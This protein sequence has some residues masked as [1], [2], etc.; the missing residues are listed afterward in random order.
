MI[1]SAEM[2]PLESVPDETPKSSSRFVWWLVVMGLGLLFLPLYMTAAALQ[3][4]SDS[5]Q[6]DLAIYQATLTAV[7]TVD[8]QT[9]A[10][11]DA[12]SETRV[13]IAQLDSANLSTQHVNWPLIASIIVNYDVT[14]LAVF[15]VQQ[16]GY[17]VVV[18]GQATSE[19]AVMNYVQALSDSEQFKRVVLQSIKLTV[20]TSPLPSGERAARLAEF[21][22]LL[23][24]KAVPA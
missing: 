1:T 4:D 12:L 18:T 3:S 6:A 7:P 5:L 17:N 8:P 14:Q 24:I 22:I 23:E 15:S 19:L 9:Q 13:Q 16:E 10:A 20:P 21:A 11:T 2:R